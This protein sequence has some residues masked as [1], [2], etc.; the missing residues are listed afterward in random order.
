MAPPPEETEETYSEENCIYLNEG[1]LADVEDGVEVEA[2]VKGT[3]VTDEEGN[4]KLE[5]T[6]VDDEPVAGGLE[7][8]EDVEARLDKSLEDLAG[9]RSY[10]PNL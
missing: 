8:M 10:K 1:T 2:T 9:E 6:M 3:I 7:P 4:R 5:V